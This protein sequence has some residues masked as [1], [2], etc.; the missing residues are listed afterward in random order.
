M[1]NFKTDTYNK[2]FENDTFIESF[3]NNSYGYSSRAND[4]IK[5]ITSTWIFILVKTK[6][7]NNSGRIDE[8]DPSILFA[9]SK[10]GHLLKQLTDELEN[11][12]SFDNFDNQGFVLIKIQRDSNNDKS[13]KTEDKDIYFKKVNLT[14][15]SFGKGIEIK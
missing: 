2:L 15:L 14:D 5:N 11:V 13:F 4:K 1:Y 6:D 12:V 3:T 10:D 9:V 8:K 7:T